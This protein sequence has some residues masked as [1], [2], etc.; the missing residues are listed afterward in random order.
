MG[1]KAVA[2]GDVGV[3]DPPSLDPSLT[4]GGGAGAGMVEA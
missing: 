3:R 2:W 4:V 1:D